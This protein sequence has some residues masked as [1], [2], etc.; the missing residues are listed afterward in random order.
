[1]AYQDW[2][3]QARKAK[4]LRA[5]AA[6]L[7]TDS[8]AGQ[9]EQTT[10]AAHQAAYMA[11][12]EWRAAN[13][14]YQALEQAAGEAEQQAALARE[15]F[16]EDMILRHAQGAALEEAVHQVIVQ[17]RP[18]VTDEIAAIQYLAVVNPL[19]LSIKTREAGKVWTA[20]QA[21]LPPFITWD[22]APVVQI[23]KEFQP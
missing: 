17:T 11:L 14:A 7:V 19:A 15:A 10:R 22:A 6:Q 13:A 23:K 8:E 2:I 5:Q 1:M 18:I 4:A 3:E 12:D 20:N 21:W 16:D 9:A